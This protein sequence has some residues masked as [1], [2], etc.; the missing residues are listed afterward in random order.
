MLFGAL[1]L[2]AALPPLAL[3]R[4]WT[5]M[6]GSL[7]LMFIG[8]SLAEAA[9]AGPVVGVAR[10]IVGLSVMGALIAP[11]TAFPGSLTSAA[12]SPV[13]P[14]P[15]DH[16]RSSGGAF[17]EV[18]RFFLMLL[19]I[20]A[21]FAL[22]QVA[23]VLGSSVDSSIASFFAYWMGILGLFLVVYSQRLL[24][25]GVGLMILLS[26]AN[27]LYA[28]LGNPGVATLLAGAVPYLCIALAVTRG[29]LTA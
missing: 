12:L 1:A 8:L 5:V 25:L 28:D 11:R 7:G 24:R 29:E 13:Q 26:A 3:S 9:L 17:D 20:V 21:A 19:A 18:F 22:S 23:P 14:E 16:S 2:A 6:V 27:L 4:R 15:E 10:F